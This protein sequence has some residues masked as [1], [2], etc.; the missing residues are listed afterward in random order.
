MWVWTSKPNFHF[1]RRTTSM[2]SM[3]L[4]RLRSP[5]FNLKRRTTNDENFALAGTGPE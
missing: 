2:T 3:M 4:V 5:T 1:E